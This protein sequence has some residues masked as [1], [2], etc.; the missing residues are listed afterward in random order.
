MKMAGGYGR[1][2]NLVFTELLAKIDESTS[3]F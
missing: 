1:V 3:R 2:Y